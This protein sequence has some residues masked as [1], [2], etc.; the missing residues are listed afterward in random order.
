[1]S[2][3]LFALDVDGVL[4]DGTIF[5]GA[6]GEELKAFNAHDGLGLTL[7]QKL[8]VEIAVISGRSSAPLVRRLEDLG[9]RHQRLAC[10]DK[11]AA[12]EDICADIG[13]T[14]ADTVFMGDDLID[15]AAMEACSYA[16]AP[17][18]AVDA[19]RMAAD[20][21][22][23]KSGGQGAVREACENLALRMGYSLQQALHTSNTKKSRVSQ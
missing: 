1:M 4:T 10:K 8:G 16:I 17:A 3:R 5:Y 9:I 6:G 15:L 18:N 19:V 7:L 13:L 22:C 14:L 21:V 12:L 23:K 20:M 11:V 2:V